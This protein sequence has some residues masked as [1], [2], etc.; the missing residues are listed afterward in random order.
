MAASRKFQL[1]FVW[2]ETSDP[3]LNRQNIR[4]K[5]DVKMKEWKFVLSNSVINIKVGLRSL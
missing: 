4:L 1:L 2:H 3:S 5:I